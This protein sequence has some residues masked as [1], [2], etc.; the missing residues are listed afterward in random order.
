M[1]LPARLMAKIPKHGTDAQW[2]CFAC[3]AWTKQQMRQQHVLVWHRCRQSPLANANDAKVKRLESSSAT[4]GLRCKHLRL[5]YSLHDN[6]ACPPTLTSTQASITHLWRNML[7]VEATCKLH[8]GPKV[9]TPLCRS[10]VVRWKSPMHQGSS[11]AD[12]KKLRTC[13]VSANRLRK[14]LAHYCT[15]T[16]AGESVVRCTHNCVV[17]CLACYISG[18]SLSAS[19]QS[20]LCRCPRR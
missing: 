12:G 13:H 7:R 11:N 9:V 1:A 16:P 17:H 10:F 14:A 3:N 20:D 2:P 6:P 18:S 5:L 8:T 19:L 4:G 15:K